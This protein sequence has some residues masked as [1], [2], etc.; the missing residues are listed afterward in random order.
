MSVPSDEELLAKLATIP[1]P[2]VPSARAARPVSTPGSSPARA[3][4]ERRRLAAL[5][6]G[7]LWIAGNLAAF[8]FR[9]DLGALP[10]P[11]VE[12]QVAVPYLLAVICLA[13][14]LAAGRLGL[15]ANVGLVAVL[16]VLAPASFCLLGAGMPLP[17]ATQPGAA[18]VASALPCLGITVAWATVPL[19]LAALVLRGA[20]PVASVRR[21]ALLGAAVGLFAGASI[22][23]HC[24]NVAHFH[25][26][27]GHALPVIA[28][29]LAGAFVVARW[30]RS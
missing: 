16:G 5:L 12:C 11:Y 10:L 2:R 19:L 23:L 27:L 15:G 20:F 21:G 25:L 4:T 26:L 24:A 30:T 29:T 3:A 8:G 6:A 22:N 1:E 18:S 17:H 7:V 14:A 28:A 13:T 9:P